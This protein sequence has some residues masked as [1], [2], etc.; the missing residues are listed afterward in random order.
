MTAVQTPKR[1]RMVRGDRKPDLRIECWDGDQRAVLSGA[2]EVR[3]HARELGTGLVVI[4][5]LVAGPADGV[6][7]YEWQAVD[8]ALVRT[9]QVEVQALI[10]GLPQTYRYVDGSPL[11]VE[12]V[13]DIA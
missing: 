8:V 4:N 13:P 2:D 10:G 6:V 7:L 3:V 1:T 9:L 12:F 11:E 5:A